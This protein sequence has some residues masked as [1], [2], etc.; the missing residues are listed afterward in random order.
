MA[1]QSRPTPDH[2]RSHDSEITEALLNPLAG[3]NSSS[4]ISFLTMRSSAVSV[5]SKFRYVNISRRYEGVRLSQAALASAFE[6]NASR[7]RPGIVNSLALSP[8]Q[9]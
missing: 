4:A 5:L 9:W 3:L 6:P 1:S 2:R 7:S 8:T